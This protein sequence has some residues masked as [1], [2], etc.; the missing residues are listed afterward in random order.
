MPEFAYGK[1]DYRSNAGGPRIKVLGVGGGGCNAVNR[2]FKEPIPGVEYI[3]VNTDAQALMRCEVPI[4]LRIGEKLTRGMGVGGNPD[5]GRQSAE[6]NREEISEL[7]KDADMVFVA[8][9]MGG[10]TGTGASPVIAELARE[11]GALTVA[12]V[13]KPFS[14]EGAKRR[15]V[16]DDGVHRLREKVD[17][18]I[19]I[20]NDRLAVVCDSKVT[21]V[22]AFRMADD[23]LRQGVQAIAELVTVPGEINLD[24]ADVKAVM[25]GAGQAW[26]GIG[27]GRG[28]TRA[29]D[30]ARN[31]TTCNLLEVSMEGAK[32]VLFNVTGGDSLTLAEVHAAAEIISQVVDPEANTFF[33]MVNDPKL[34]DEVKITLIATGFPMNDTASG[35]VD[36]LSN[37][38]NSIGQGTGVSTPER[39]VDI[40]IPPFLRKAQMARRMPHN[41]H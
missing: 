27:R 14:F 36:E 6:E 38:L 15:K 5:I 40:D 16:A 9:G 18:M 29:T 39:P 31:A 4:R 10:G 24:F 3:A 1:E 30:A 7:L 37:L 13:T 17:T 19:A 28:E 33:G 11:A 34:E 25:Q 12:V 26:L 22:N 2:M 23:V 21:M 35:R 20:P 8:A 41:G 32:G